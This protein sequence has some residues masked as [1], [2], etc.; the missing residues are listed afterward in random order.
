MTIVVIVIAA[1]VAVFIGIA[2]FQWLWNTTMID[3]FGLRQITYW[4][5]FRLLLLA[6]MLFGGMHYSIGK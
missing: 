4:Q 6:G 2:I 5:A 3:V 1:I